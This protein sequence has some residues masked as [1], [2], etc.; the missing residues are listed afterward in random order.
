MHAPHLQLIRTWALR[1]YVGSIAFVLAF[2][3]G[4]GLH[5][6][7]TPQ[8]HAFTKEIHAMTHLIICV[9]VSLARA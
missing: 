5:W 6:Q 9:V 4:T 2:L 7:L 3:R 1:M 8:L